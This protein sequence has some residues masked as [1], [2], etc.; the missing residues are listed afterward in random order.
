M[1]ESHSR[2]TADEVADHLQGRVLPPPTLM[3]V[4]ETAAD[5]RVNRSTVWRKIRAGELP[6]LRIGGR[7]LVRRADADAFLARCLEGVA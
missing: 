2:M 1:T 4:D 3:T 5:W 7:T 6:V